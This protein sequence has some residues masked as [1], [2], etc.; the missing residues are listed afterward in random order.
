MPWFG[1]I[2]AKLLHRKPVST[3]NIQCS[4]CQPPHQPLASSWECSS[5]CCESPGHSETCQPRS[6]KDFKTAEKIVLNAVK[7]K[8]VRKQTPPPKGPLLPIYDSKPEER[9]ENPHLNCMTWLCCISFLFVFIL[10]YHSC[11]CSSRETLLPGALINHPSSLL[12]PSPYI[13]PGKIAPSKPDFALQTPCH[14]IP[15]YSKHS[16]YKLQLNK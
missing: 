1:D 10:I 8:L 7:Q 14:G 6:P 12:L 15:D 9:E 4:R 5:L 13:T 3:Q 2:N 16:L 11:P